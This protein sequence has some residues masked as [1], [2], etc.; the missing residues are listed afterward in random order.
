MEKIL[1]MIKFILLKLFSMGKIKTNGIRNYIGAG[2]KIVVKNKSK[3]EFGAKTWISD[4]CALV[5]TGKGLVIGENCYFNSNVR[6]FSMDQIS[7]GDNCLFGP[8]IVIVDHNHKYDDVEQ[9][10]CK[11]GYKTAPVVIG[12][13]IWFGANTVITKGVTISDNIVVGAGSVITRDLLTPGV[14]VGNPAIKIKELR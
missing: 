10:I 6:I 7:I 2:S 9:Y 8:N 4:Y 11:Q 14:Y 5:S 12:N 13:N 1:G 3:I